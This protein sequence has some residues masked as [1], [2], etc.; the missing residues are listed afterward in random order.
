MFYFIFLFYSIF[1]LKNINLQPGLPAYVLL[2]S[3]GLGPWT[4]IWAFYVYD[5]A[6]EII[7]IF[8]S[9]ALEK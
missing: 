8:S 7:S 3:P 5:S 2:I 9:F 6:R 1:L 4:H